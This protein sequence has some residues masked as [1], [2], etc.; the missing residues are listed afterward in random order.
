[1]L[2]YSVVLIVLMLFNWAPGILKWREKH[3]FTAAAVT[4]K[5]GKKKKE[6]Q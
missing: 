3:G 4:Q 5:F 1:M 6:V 2:I